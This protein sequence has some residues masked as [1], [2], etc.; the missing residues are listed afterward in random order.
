[1]RQKAKHVR[2]RFSS[3]LLAS[4]W[5]VLAGC[6]WLW[7]APLGTEPITASLTF[8]PAVPGPIVRREP[9]RVIV[10]LAIEEKVM[11][12]SDG[13]QYEFWTYNGHVPG[14]FIRLRQGDS[15]RTAWLG[16]RK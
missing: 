4:V 3:H 15:F 8:A 1:M 9:A 2:E 7:A 13:V 10:H 11:D 5:S 12:L 6:F 16:G 14:P